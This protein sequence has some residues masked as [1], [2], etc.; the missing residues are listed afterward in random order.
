MSSQQLKQSEY[1]QKVNL[2]N[3][4]ISNFQNIRASLQTRSEDTKLEDLWV[5][6]RET[7]NSEYQ[8]LKPTP[9]ESK[10]VN[11]QEG[12]RDTC[13]KLVE[14]EIVD[15]KADSALLN[16]EN[17][18]PTP[19]AEVKTAEKVETTTEEKQIEQS[20]KIEDSEIKLSSTPPT[21]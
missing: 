17:L 8:K 5:Q 21:P 15:I 4:C 12:E 1:S 6:L 13:N 11:V 16:S 2:V 10:I 14:S 20:I 7:V 19:E 3:N 9:P 18:I